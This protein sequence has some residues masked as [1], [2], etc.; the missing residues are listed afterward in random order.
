[1]NFDLDQSI[2]IL[3][4]TPRVFNELLHGLSS[5]WYLANEGPDTW[6]AFDIVG[7]LIHGEK[8]DWIPRAKIILG[9]LPDKTFEP[10]DRFA[11]LKDSQAKSM[12][13]LLVEFKELR[14]NNIGELKELNLQESDF[15][16]IGIHPDLGEVT[17]ANLISTWTVHDMSHIYQVSRV[18]SKR[19]SKDVGPWKAYIRVIKDA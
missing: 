16:R 7:H 14:T 1:M 12:T 17:L 10:F 11:Q 2:E 13:D 4:R 15:A 3:E 5:G 8:T 19:Y 6:S 18:L 9:N